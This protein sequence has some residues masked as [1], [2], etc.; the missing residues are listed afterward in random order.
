MIYKTVTYDTL[1]FVVGIYEHHGDISFVNPHDDTYQIGSVKIDDN[2][3]IDVLS[4][5][6]LE[7]LFFKAKKGVTDG[8]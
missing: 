7:N 4:A 3:F 5:F 2:E 8:E 6:A 1:D